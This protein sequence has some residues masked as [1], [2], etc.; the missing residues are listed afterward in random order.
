[1]DVEWTEAELETRKKTFAG[2]PDRQLTGWLKRYQRMVTSA[3]TGA[4]LE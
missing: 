4:V 1:L 2:A 3:N